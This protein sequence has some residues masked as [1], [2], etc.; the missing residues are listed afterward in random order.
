MKISL[1]LPLA[2][3]EFIDRYLAEHDEASRSEVVR[4]AL[5]LLRAEELGDAYEAAWD[6]WAEGGAELWESTTDDGL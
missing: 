1:R 5:E 6:E 3:I 4:K 2:D